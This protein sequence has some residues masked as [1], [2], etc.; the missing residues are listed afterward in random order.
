MS[1]LNIFNVNKSGLAPTF[2]G[3]TA[4]SAGVFQAVSK[5]KTGGPQDTVQISELAQNLS[6][7]AAELFNSF[8]AKTRGTLE[9][10][11]SSGHFSAK[12]MASALDGLATTALYERYSKEMVPTAEQREIAGR[13]AQINKAQQ[14]QMRET[15]AALANLRPL[16]DPNDPD[17]FDPTT[18]D[19]L[20]AA[21]DAIREKYDPDDGLSNAEEL[22]LLMGRYAA[23][24]LDRFQSLNLGDE[25]ERPRGATLISDE[26]RRNVD[27]LVETLKKIGVDQERFQYALASFAGDKFIPEIGK[28]PAP[29]WATWRDARRQGAV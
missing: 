23:V 5:P 4:E 16:S 25:A 27:R 3:A 29:S 11:A 22:G 10:L 8:D 18:G 24:T 28:N 1:A 15:G 14:A 13:S 19:R 12:E 7:R 17:S 20:R 9:G 2:S 21:V 6:G 26:S